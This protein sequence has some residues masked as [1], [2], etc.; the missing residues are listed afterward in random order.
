MKQNIHLRGKSGIWFRP[1]HVHT[2]VAYFSHALHFLLNRFLIFFSLIVYLY[3]Q[4]FQSPCISEF[5]PNL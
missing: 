1:T 2:W 4:G 5:W 3:V